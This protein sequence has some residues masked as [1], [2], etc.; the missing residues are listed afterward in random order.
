MVIREPN[1]PQT[2]AGNHSFDQLGVF[3][4]F[5]WS[6]STESLP[7]AYRNSTPLFTVFT[8]L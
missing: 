3:V 1:H 8:G 2:L 7:L 4:D 5:S 6:L